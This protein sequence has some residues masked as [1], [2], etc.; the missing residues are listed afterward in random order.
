[1]MSFPLNSLSPS[2]Q[3]STNSATGTQYFTT[4]SFAKIILQTAKKRSDGSILPFVPRP[5]S[6]TLLVS[7]S[8]HSSNRQTAK[9]R[10]DGSLRPFV[11]ITRPPWLRPRQVEVSKVQPTVLHLD[12]SLPLSL[13]QSLSLHPLPYFIEAAPLLNPLS[14]IAVI[15]FLV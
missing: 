3:A 12:P 9:K 5:F 14:L 4:R 15:T 10:S 13:T 11:P 6:P 7:P 1:M 8:S 2:T